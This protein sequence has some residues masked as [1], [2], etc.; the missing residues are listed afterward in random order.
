MRA[1]KFLGFMVRK[2]GIDPNPDK[3]QAIMYLPEPKGVKDIQRLTGRMGA[4][5]RF[6]SKSAD[7]ALPFFM[8]L[9]GKKKF[10][11]GEEQSKAFRRPEI[12]CNYI[13]RPR[14]KP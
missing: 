4:L 14:L 9:R 12:H 8:L 11:W 2:R 10:K 5:T 1:G 13:S 3:V 6:I 7:K